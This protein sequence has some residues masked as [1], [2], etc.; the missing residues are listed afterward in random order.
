[1]S[2]LFQRL[3]EL[4]EERPAADA[5]STSS[6]VNGNATREELAAELL[7]LRARLVEQKSLY[8]DLFADATALRLEY[9]AFRRTAEREKRVSMQQRA[10]DKRVLEELR[11]A[12]PLGKTDEVYATLTEAKLADLQAQ[13]QKAVEKEEKAHKRQLEAEQARLVAEASKKE[14][15]Q[16]LCQQ[17]ERFKEAMQHRNEELERQL[18][19]ARA[20]AAVGGTVAEE[21]LPEKEEALAPNG[22][23]DGDLNAN[24]D[25][26]ASTSERT[27]QVQ[28]SLVAALQREKQLRA[29]LVAE[30]DRSQSKLEGVKWEHMEAEKKVAELKTEMDT[31]R[32]KV[33]QLENIIEAKA[34][35]YEL[36]E[37]DYQLII[38]QSE[39]NI[40]RLRLELQE[41]KHIAESK[42]QEWE[43]ALAREQEMEARHAAVAGDAECLKK[44]T[45]EALEE[46]RVRFEGL[47]QEREGLLQE[48]QSACHALGAAL[49]HV[50]E[51]NRKQADRL[52][53]LRQ[54]LEQ[55]QLLNSE[56][57]HM[58]V[59]SQ[60]LIVLREEELMSKEEE[61]Q[62]L[63]QR[64]REEEEAH[65]RTRE[66]MREL[67]L[68]HSEAELLRS[69]QVTVSAETA[70][71]AAALERECSPTE[72]K[73][74]AQE[75]EE[76]QRRDQSI[77]QLQFQLD[78]LIAQN[79]RFA[80]YR[81]E[82]AAKTRQFEARI[83]ELEAERSAVML[84]RSLAESTSIAERSHA[85]RQVTA[86]TAMGSGVATSLET[87][88]AAPSERA[89]QQFVSQAVMSAKKLRFSA[90]SRLRRLTVTSLACIVFVLLATTY[91]AAPPSTQSLEKAEAA[92]ESLRE[93]YT[94][95]STA[96]QQCRALLS[97]RR[98]KE[99][100]H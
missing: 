73:V 81:E 5:L 86:E 4:G 10:N 16:K 63:R 54:E 38:R 22:S 19:E 49:Q 6:D 43:Q 14:D 11:R 12:G 32:S 58:Q 70:A 64:L 65:A 75:A 100:N 48:Q 50:R 85:S 39:D 26:T 42:C 67:E 56:M 76:L 18:L 99:K 20:A 90:S 95:A 36:R 3:I 62:G 55:A 34:E 44:A 79:A 96:L 60:R 77:R 27:P 84:Q 8:D 82:Q 28:A 45:N 53:E 66:R 13:L 61:R 91:F 83:R 15:V 80:F 57:E 29:E 30:R 9:D 92:M 21:S 88:Y 69:G 31:L 1:M 37:K 7:Q 24:D 52:E 94:A 68:H 33:A 25:A 78:D 17:F 98:D 71:G 40:T 93:R 74:A 2:R 97:E 35:E 72:A 89:R 87:L 47:L 23:A 41:A 51:D 59:Q 46:Q